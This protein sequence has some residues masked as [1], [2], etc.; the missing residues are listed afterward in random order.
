[1]VHFAGTGL[2]FACLVPAALLRKKRFLFSAPAIG[3]L[4]AWAAHFGLQHNVPATFSRP[5]WSIVSYWRMI[6][7]TAVRRLG[8]ELE[9]AGVHHSAVS[10]K[11]SPPV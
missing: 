4:S 9:R 8:P 11:T 1:M 2:A 3:Y 10:P 6:G 5:L 7:L